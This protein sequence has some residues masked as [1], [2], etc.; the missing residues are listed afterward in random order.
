MDQSGSTGDSGTPPPVGWAAPP[1]PAAPKGTGFNIQDFAYFR[2]LITPAFMTVIYIIGAVG[3]TFAA[4]ASLVAGQ[5]IAGLLV[6]IFA[7]LY[8]RIICEFIMV[9]FRMNDSLKS[10]DGRGKG[11]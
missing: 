1:P 7:N 10:I 2:Y 5:A 11:M 4:L 3:I 8:W 9:L 6:F